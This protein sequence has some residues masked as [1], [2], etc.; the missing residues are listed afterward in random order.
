MPIAAHEAIANQIMLTL[1]RADYWSQKQLDTNARIK[2]RST[3]G[4]T[5]QSWSRSSLFYLPCQAAN[6]AYSFFVDHS[7][8]GRQP[9]D[10][11]QWAGY[12]ANHAQPAPSIEPLPSEQH[13]PPIAPTECPKLLA[14]REPLREEQVAER[15]ADRQQAAIERWRT[16][17][18]KTGNAA[19]FQ[20]G[21]DLRRTGMT[22]PEIETVL[23][24]EAEQRSSRKE[25]RRQIKSVMRSLCRSL[26]IAA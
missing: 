14:V 21:I 7:D 6:P 17:P 24:Q 19:F 8:K 11:Y 9:L 5:C 22:L 10:P 12:A 2:S 1:N 16:A 3:M 25:R 23:R 13:L 4:S 15:R 26:Q 20:L 18:P